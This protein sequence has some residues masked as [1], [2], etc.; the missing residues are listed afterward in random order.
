MFRVRRWKGV[1]GRACRTGKSL[2]RIIIFGLP[3]VRTVWRNGI[4]I[5]CKQREAAGAGGGGGEWERRYHLW[6]GGGEREDGPTV[7]SLCLR[8]VTVR[9]ADFALLDD[10]RL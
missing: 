3:G 1:E 5:G 2:D 9:D 6:P 7:A 4:I 10:K 8:P